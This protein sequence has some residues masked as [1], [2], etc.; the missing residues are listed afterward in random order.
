MPVLV[1]SLI[2]GKY[3][4]LPLDFSLELSRGNIDGF[5]G[6]TINGRNKDIDAT[7]SFSLILIPN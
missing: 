7:G 2:A 5:I 6:E 3:T 1:N 4:N